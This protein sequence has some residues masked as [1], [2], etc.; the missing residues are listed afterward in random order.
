MESRKFAEILKDAAAERIKSY[1]IITARFEMTH[2]QA[3]AVACN[4]AQ[5]GRSWCGPIACLLSSSWN[6][7]MNWA[8][9]I[10][11]GI[12]SIEFDNSDGAR[13]S[14]PDDS[15]GSI[16]DA[17]HRYAGWNEGAPYP[18]YVLYCFGSVIGSG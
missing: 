15:I 7:S 6:D 16:Q 17:M 18:R 11:K 1:D 9:I 4:R 12:W 2:A 8:D 14:I 3:A 10:L 13:H 5:V